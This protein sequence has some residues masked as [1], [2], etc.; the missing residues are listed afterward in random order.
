[1]G[2][3]DLRDLPDELLIERFRV[4]RSH[5]AFSEIFRRYRKP[6]YISCLAVLRSPPAAEEMPERSPLP[7]AAAYSQ[8]GMTFAHTRLRSTRLDHA[9]CWP[10]SRLCPLPIE[11]AERLDPYVRDKYRELSRAAIAGDREGPMA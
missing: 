6:I 5:E 2:A 8:M 11:F 7:D 9:E 4:T 10:T 3:A 1:M